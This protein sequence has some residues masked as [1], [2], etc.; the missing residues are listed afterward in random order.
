[1]CVLEQS[2]M[3]VLR[4]ENLPVPCNHHTPDRTRCLYRTRLNWTLNYR[5]LDSFRLIIY[6]VI[7][8]A[9]RT[10]HTNGND[11]VLVNHYLKI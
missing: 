11:I 1:M 6:M 9:L 10:P 3:N 8:F 2:K 4:L 5:I 7:F